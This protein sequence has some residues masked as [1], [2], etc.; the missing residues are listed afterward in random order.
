MITLYHSP[1]SRST[2]VVALLKDLDALDK[3]A[4]EI[5]TIPRQDGSGARDP[6]N[7]HPDGK[8]PFLVQDGHPIWESSAIIQH[9]AELF[10]AAGLGVPVGDP[11]RGAYLSWLA[12]YA[13]VVEPV[14]VLQALGLD[15]PG[16]AKTFRTGDDLKARLAAALADRPYL[17]GDRYTAADLLLHSPYAWFGKP[18]VPA[19]DAWVDRCMDR[20]GARYAAAFDAEHGA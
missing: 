15:H 18:G 5:V 7:P 1:N 11:R 19:I 3:V 17:L 12:W 6:R 14:L 9:L 13:G 4:I 10:P 20:P 2:R 8:V 16:I